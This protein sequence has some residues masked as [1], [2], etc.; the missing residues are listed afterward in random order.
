MWTARKVWVLA[1]MSDRGLYVCKNVCACN[2]AR[3]NFCT[4][5]HKSHC[6]VKG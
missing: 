5:K 6:C 4:V 3:E 2:I 1:S